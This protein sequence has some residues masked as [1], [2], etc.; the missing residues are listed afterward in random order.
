MWTLFTCSVLLVCRL[1]FPR[2]GWIA[3]ALKFSF[4]FAD[5]SRD[6]LAVC[7][8]LLSDRPDLL[9]VLLDPVSLYGSACDRI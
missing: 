7:A 8:D 4:G 9:E 3:P 6:I 2:C 1:D 5:A